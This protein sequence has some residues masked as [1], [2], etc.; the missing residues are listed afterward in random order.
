MNEDLL[1]E[2][3][4]WKPNQTQRHEAAII[5][6]LRKLHRLAR[7]EGTQETTKKRLGLTPIDRLSQHEELLAR[8]HYS[9]FSSSL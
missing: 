5:P 8:H 7:L 6:W 2:I 4:S 3:F 1:F 9:L